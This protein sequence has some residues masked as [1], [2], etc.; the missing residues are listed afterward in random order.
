[1]RNF[2]FFSVIYT[3]TAVAMVLVLRDNPT[4]LLSFALLNSMS[5]ASSLAGYLKIFGILLIAAL[6]LT[7][8]TGLK[9]RFVP[10]LYALMGCLVF[11]AGFS[12]FKT[13]IPFLVAFWSDPL[14]ADL[15]ALLHLGIDPWRLTH[16]LSEVINPNIVTLFYFGIWTLP[17]VFLPL[18]I[19]I[20]DS[21]RQRQ[22]RF[23]VLHIFCWVGLGN[24]LATAFSSVGPIYFDAL[25]GGTR[26]AELTVAL[27]TSG[28]SDS[29]LGAVQA[30][31]WTNYAEKAQA[32][33]SGISA[34]PSVHVG[35]STVFAVYL[36][37]RNKWLAP[38]GIAF[39]ATIGFFSVYNGWHY[40]VDGYV[41][42]ILVI[43]LWQAQRFYAKLRAKV[44]IDPYIPA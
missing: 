40:A 31:L 36:A 18:I 25:L 28:I 20:T 35:A 42:A 27:K 44:A 22:H 3:A 39:V 43:A 11:A 13:S 16:K 37:E 29:H 10:S 26:F 8:H 12:L 30:N 41:S 32:I 23:L 5:L 38:V 14:M 17:A 7:R 21:D 4:Q 9:S 34:F 6:W 2:F 33:G 15:D 1:M 24:V 19:A